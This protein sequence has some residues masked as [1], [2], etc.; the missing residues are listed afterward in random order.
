MV[1]GGYDPRQIDKFFLADVDLI[2]EGWNETPS[3]RSIVS[4]IASA[5]G[6]KWNRSL[7]APAQESHRPTVAEIKSAFPA[8]VF[9]I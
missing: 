7:S 2:F 8:G 6:V 5:V 1:D 9:R 4:A 3:L